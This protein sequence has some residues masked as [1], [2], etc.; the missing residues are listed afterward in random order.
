M[1]LNWIHRRVGDTEVYFLADEPA[2]AV[3]TKCTF[4]LRDARPELWNPETGEISPV[5]VY[6]ETEAG[7]AVPLRFEAGGSAFVVFR[8]QK[9]SADS[10]VSVTR[11]G[12]PVAPL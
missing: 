7:I 1:K 4:R 9:E 3:E 10:V 11:D 2:S 8:P 12:E 5:A 6:D